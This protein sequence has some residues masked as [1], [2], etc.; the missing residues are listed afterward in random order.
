[1]EVVEV[2]GQVAFDIEDLKTEEVVGDGK[3][4]PHFE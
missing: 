3:M 4:A 2:V 1:M